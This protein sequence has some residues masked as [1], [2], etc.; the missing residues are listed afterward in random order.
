MLLICPVLDL[1]CIWSK[2]NLFLCRN[3]KIC[4]VS[5]RYFIHDIKS[6]N[7]CPFTKYNNWTKRNNLTK[8]NKRSKD[9]N[10]LIDCT[11]I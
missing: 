8:Q 4:L 9:N 11:L 5:M 7:K 2:Y 1:L 6:F 3:K 10:S